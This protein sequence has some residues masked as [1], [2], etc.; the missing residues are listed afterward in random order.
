MCR[1]FYVKV[2]TKKLENTDCNAK[3]PGKTESA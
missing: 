3:W 1:K 2:I